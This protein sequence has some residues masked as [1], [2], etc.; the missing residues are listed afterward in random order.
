MLSK[1]GMDLPVK[2][3]WLDWLTAPVEG[4][5][6]IVFSEVEIDTGWTSGAIHESPK[7]R[8]TTLRYQRASE[9][10]EA[11]HSAYASR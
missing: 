9:N 5:R 11:T 1:T 8:L 7:D 10:V 6:G 2:R 4:A 3:C